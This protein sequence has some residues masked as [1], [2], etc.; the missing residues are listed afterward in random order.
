MKGTI[1]PA[2]LVIASAFIIIIYG[3]LFILS[4][5]FDFAQRQIAN[6]RALNIAE[7]GI[8]YYH[9]HLDIDPD[10]YTDGTNNPDLQPYEHEY[11]DPQGE[12]IGKFALEIEA[13]TES[14][15]VVTIRSTGWLYQYPKVKRTI[16]VQYGKVVL[17]RYAFLHNSNMWFGDDITVNGPVFSNGGIRLDGHNSST[18][19]SAKEDY[20]CGVETG[21]FGSPSCKSECTWSSADSTCT[22]PGIWGNGEI[23]E[24]WD[25]PN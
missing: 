2:L 13:P 21:C 17:T 15:Q 11:N 19:E 24:L 18:V 6:E 16:E 12:A 7:A 4:L 25:F 23:D 8:N 1:T 5:Q 20:I 9:W 14:H 10:D 3:L 22:C